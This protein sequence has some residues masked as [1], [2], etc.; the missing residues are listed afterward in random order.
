MC[1]RSDQNNSTKFQNPKK[2][3]QKNYNNECY[4]Q[5]NE[6]MV[7]VLGKTYLRQPYSNG[8]YFKCSNSQKNEHIRGAGDATYESSIFIQY[9]LLKSGLAFIIGDH[10]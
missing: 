4:Q 6:T 1:V 10:E 9:P 2:G 8:Y 7:T 3:Y 5:V